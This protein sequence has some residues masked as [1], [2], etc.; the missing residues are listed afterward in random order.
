MGGEFVATDNRAV[1]DV[2][3]NHRSA[4]PAVCA[5]VAKSRRAAVP[6]AVPRPIRGAGPALPQGAHVP[7]ASLT[8]ADRTLTAEVP[9][10]DSS[11]RG[12]PQVEWIR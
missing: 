12:P 3:G 5:P 9:I 8:W 10:E 4:V 7:P 2:D 1:K 11:A 6:N